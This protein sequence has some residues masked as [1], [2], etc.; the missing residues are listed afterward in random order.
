MLPYAEVVGDPIAH[1]KSPTLHRFWLGAMGIEADYRAH[2][3]RSHDLQEYLAER[4]GDPKWR[5]CN[6]TAPHK[7]IMVSFL[8]ELSPCAAAIGAAN[9]AYCQDGRLIG[10]NSDIEGIAEAL[11]QGSIEGKTVIILGAGGAARGAIYH[12]VLSGASEIRLLARRPEAASK[13]ASAGTGSCPVRV[14]AMDEV[15]NIKGADLLVNASPLGMAQ[16]PMPDSLI[17][18]L[19][20]L[21]AGGLV[22]DMVYEPLETPLLIAARRC[23]L[24]AV[25]GLTMLIGQARRSFHLFFGE[26]PPPTLDAELRSHLSPSPIFRPIVLVGPRCRVGR[27]AQSSFFRQRPGN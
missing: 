6:L 12:L 24:T 2:H 22:F 10:D 17:Q 14:F 15:S 3:I 11:P 1:S 21:D 16:A 26:E 7:E 23:S 18:S 13:L 4:R 9:I 20:T 25:D 8:D 5:G 27:K 19:A